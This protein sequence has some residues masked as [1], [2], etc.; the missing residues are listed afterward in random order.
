MS[1]KERLNKY[2]LND[3]NVG[4]QI[5]NDLGG[6]P[7]MSEF[8]AFMEKVKKH[9]LSGKMCRYHRKYARLIMRG[10]TP[11]IVKAMADPILEEKQLL[12]ASEVF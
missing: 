9:R 3:T 8:D 4:M 10:H 7:K 12:V 5:A 1:V 2:W 6:L 11:P